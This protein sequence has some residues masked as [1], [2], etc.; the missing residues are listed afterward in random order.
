MCVHRF[1][2]VCILCFCK[3]L[4]MRVYH[5]FV[6][7]CICGYIKYLDGCLVL[8]LADQVVDLEKGPE[9]FPLSTHAH[10]HNFQFVGHGA[11]ID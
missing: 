10:R 11:L 6:R 8:Y 7:V 3:D 2:Y 4:Y 9:L 1:A 5:V